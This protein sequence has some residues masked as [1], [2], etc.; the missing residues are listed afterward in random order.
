MASYDII[1]YYV[2]TYVPY[3][4]RGIGLVRITLKTDL[5]AMTYVAQM[6]LTSDQ[7]IVMKRM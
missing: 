6:F 1:G 7:V 2:Y 5:L 3:S 4:T